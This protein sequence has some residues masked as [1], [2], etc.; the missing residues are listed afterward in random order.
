MTDRVGLGWRKPLAAAI[1]ANRDAFDVVEVI[2]EDWF[3][4]P[5]ALRTLAAQL[6]V[7]IH[8]VSLGLASSEPVER[9]RL[10]AIARVVEA[11]R[12]RFWSEH[13]AFVRGGGIE[14]GHLAAPPRT[15][16]T[17]DGLAR[18]VE[19]AAAI[20]GS[21]PL[22]ENVATL[23]DPPAS[24]MDEPTWTARALEASGCDLLLDLHNLYANAT[25]FGW[26]PRAFL[27]A[28]PPSRI[29]AIHLAGGRWMS[30]RVLD[31]H[32]HDVPDPVFDLLVEVAARVPHP[33]TVILER[34][35]D[36]PAI[37]RL[38]AELERARQALTHGRSRPSSRVHRP[39]STRD[40]R[41]ET[42]DGAEA[43]LARIYTDADPRGAA[44]RA[45]LDPASLDVEGLALAARSFAK[46]R[47]H[48]AA[49]RR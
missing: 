29:R 28:I 13:L 31:D 27:D 46:K 10:D 30:G 7:V 1:L 3:D 32:L 19:R 5:R 20:V 12:P 16:A 36:Y 35:G 14:I 22:L 38:L 42:G 33:L 6:P 8:G 49:H 25:N 45:G 48:N 23:V 9:K 43:L 44:E 26:D 47:A 2:A 24:A 34:D 4:H 40:E 11:A 15:A 21:R 37:E 17:I 18:N 39:S 41:R